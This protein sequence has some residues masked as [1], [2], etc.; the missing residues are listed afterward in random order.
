MCPADERAGDWEEAPLPLGSSGWR[1]RVEGRAIAQQELS[2]NLQFPKEAAVNSRRE[3]GITHWR[4][5][6]IQK[7]GCD[8]GGFG[9]G[10]KV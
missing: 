1:M 8:G 6:T 10:P 2:E 5:G 3:V 9:L 7:R 4:G